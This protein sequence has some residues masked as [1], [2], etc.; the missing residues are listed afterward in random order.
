MTSTCPIQGRSS[1]DGRVSVE[2]TISG[3]S[4]EIEPQPSAENTAP[5]AQTTGEKEI[6]RLTVKVKKMGNPRKPRAIPSSESTEGQ[7]DREMDVTDR[8]AK[9][10]DKLCAGI[11]PEERIAYAQAKL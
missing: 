5:E 4:N 10:I 2:A 1:T 9:T 7:T 11:D 3:V 8:S 6:D